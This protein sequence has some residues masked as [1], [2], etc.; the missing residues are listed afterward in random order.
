MA[1]RVCQ[2]DYIRDAVMEGGQGTGRLACVI[3]RGPNHSHASRSRE[4]EGD[5]TAEEI[6]T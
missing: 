6:A 4:A 1:K 3:Q 5:L 2:H